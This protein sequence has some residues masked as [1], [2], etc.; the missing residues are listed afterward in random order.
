[1][2]T[3]SKIEDNVFSTIYIVCI[4][5]FAKKWRTPN[6]MGLLS[7]AQYGT[8]ARLQMLEA[9]PLKSF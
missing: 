3:I 2:H 9:L 7:G 4:Y 5:V 8:H 6:T 1:M